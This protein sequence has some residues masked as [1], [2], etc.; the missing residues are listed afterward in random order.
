ML[1]E[2][3]LNITN[4]D[5]LALAEERFGKRGALALWDGGLPGKEKAGSFEAL[6]EIHRALFG[7]VFEFAGK[8]RTVNMSKGEFTFA[9]AAFLD[10]VVAD[11]EKMSQGTF[12]EI[13]EKY[14]EMNVAHPF[15]EGNGRSMRIWLDQMLR[16]E[17]KVV[18]DWSTIEKEAYLT[19]MAVSPFDDGKIKGVLR[20]ALTDRIHDRELYQ[21][22][23]DQ[24]FY[25]EGYAAYQTKEL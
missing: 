20:S 11:V 19:A 23:I 12:E 24:S 10:S 3:K 7:E 18:V 5:E 9:M 8:L 13:V 6:T 1:L 15:R 14:V 4:D 16:K 25:F 22:G 2:N 21:R 17:L